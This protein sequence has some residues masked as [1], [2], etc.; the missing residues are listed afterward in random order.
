MRRTGA[1]KKFFGDRNFHAFAS[2]PVAMTIRRS[3]LT[4]SWSSQ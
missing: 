3:S 2:E 1:E 4:F